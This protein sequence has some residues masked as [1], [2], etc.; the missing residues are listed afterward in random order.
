MSKRPSRR[1]EHEHE[2]QQSTDNRHRDRSQPERGRTR[3]V[4]AQRRSE[5]ALQ[6][7]IHIRDPNP[8]DDSDHEQQ[9]QQQVDE[10][11]N[12]NTQTN[13]QTNSTSVTSSSL[14]NL[15]RP[16]DLYR[17]PSARSSLSE[18]VSPVQSKKKKKKKEKRTNSHERRRQ[19][20]REEREQ[21]AA[22][23]FEHFNK[24]NVNSESSSS[25]SSSASSR[26]SSIE[27]KHDKPTSK[28][29]STTNKQS[30]TSTSKPTSSTARDSQATAPT[31]NSSTRI[32]SSGTKPTQR[33]VKHRP[34]SPPS[35]ESDNESDSAISGATSESDSAG[36]RNENESIIATNHSIFS[37]NSGAF[38]ASNS[39]Y[40]KQEK[41]LL[42]KKKKLEYSKVDFKLTFNNCSITLKNKHEFKEYKSKL[43]IY[44]QTVGARDLVTKPTEM[45]WKDLSLPFVAAATPIIVYREFRNV[46]TRLCGLLLSTVA[47]H[48]TNISSIEQEIKTKY[49][50]T[51]PNFIDEINTVTNQHVTDYTGSFF[52]GNPFLLFSYLEDRFTS[53]KQSLAYM[54]NKIT[55]L[56]IDNIANYHSTQQW[57]DNFQSNLMEVEK[58]MALQPPEPGRYLNNITVLSI[59]MSQLN[60]SKH[61]HIKRRLHELEPERM[62]LDSLISM[63]V[64]EENDRYAVRNNKVST[65]TSNTPNKNKGGNQQAQA[66]L[67]T[68]ETSNDQTLALITAGTQFNTGTK[69]SG[70]KK[71]SK[72]NRNKRN[73]DN[74]PASNK[75][76][77]VSATGDQNSSNSNNYYAS[78]AIEQ[79]DSDYSSGNSSGD[80][81]SDDS[82]EDCYDT[83]DNSNGI[84]YAAATYDEQ[85]N[86]MKNRTV[87][88]ISTNHNV[89]DLSKVWILDSGAT[90]HLTCIKSVFEEDTLHKL[91]PSVT[92]TGFAGNSTVAR[93]VGTVQLN[94]NLNITNM[95]Y[96]PGTKT[97]LISQS[98]LIQS[99]LRMRSHYH[100]Q[101]N[102]VH[103]I[104]FFEPAG[105]FKARDLITFCLCGRGLWI[106]KSNHVIEDHMEQQVHIRPRVTKKKETHVLVRDMIAA[107]K[108]TTSNSTSTSTSDTSTC[109]TSSTTVAPYSHSTA[110]PRPSTRKQ[111]PKKADVVAMN[112]SMA[113]STALPATQAI[114]KFAYVTEVTD[115]DT[116]SEEEFTGTQ[117]MVL[118]AH[119]TTP[120]TITD[121]NVITGTEQHNT[122]MNTSTVISTATKTNTLSAAE[123]HVRYGHVS[124]SRAAL[125]ALNCSDPVYDAATCETCAAV[126]IRKKRTGAGTYVDLYAGPM[127]RLDADIQGPITDVDELGRIVRIRSIG[128]AYYLLNVICHHSRF[129]FSIPL[130]KKS[131]AAQHIIN[132]INNI[133]TQY[134]ISV[135]CVHSDNG[136]EF[137][138]GTLQSYYTANGIVQSLS[139]AYS[140]STNGTVERC[141][142]TIM[143]M[144]KSMLSSSSAPS[145]LWGEA[146]IQAAR[147]HNSVPLKSLDF[148]S[149]LEVVTGRPAHVP[150]TVFGSDC[151]YKIEQHLIGKL[152]TAGTRG[153]VIGK[154]PNGIGYRIYTGGTVLVS[155]N[156]KLYNGS[157]KFMNA[158]TSGDTITD[159]HDE[160]VYVDG[161]EINN[162]SNKYEFSN[163]INLVNTDDEP[164]I[165]NDVDSTATYP[166]HADP[167]RTTSQSLS[168]ATHPQSTIQS[169]S[170]TTNNVSNNTVTENEIVQEPNIDYTADDGTDD[171]YSAAD[172]Q[173]D[174]EYYSDD[175]NSNE[176][177][178]SDDDECTGNDEI[179]TGTENYTATQNFTG[180]SNNTLSPI[181][182]EENNY[183]KYDVNNSYGVLGSISDNEYEDENNSSSEYD[184]DQIDYVPPTT[185]TTS[186]GRVSSAPTPF[187]PFVFTA[188]VNHE[189]TGT[190][191]T[192]TRTKSKFS[193]AASTT[194]S[195]GT[196]GVQVN[197]SQRS[198][199]AT[200]LFKHNDHSI[201][202][203]RAPVIGGT[204][205]D[206]EDFGLQSTATEPDEPQTFKSAMRSRDAS[207]WS[208]SM[209]DE[210][211]S[212]IK[213]QVLIKWNR[214]SNTRILGTRWVYKIKK[215]EHNQPI[216]WKSRLVAKG[217][218]QVEDLDFGETFSPVAHFDTLRLLLAIS[219]I[220]DTEIKQVD[221]KTAFL[222]A[223]LDEEIFISVPQGI[224]DEC[225]S[226]DIDPKQHCFKLNRALYG[227]KQSPRMW[228]KLLISELLLLGYQQCSSDPCLLFKHVPGSSI[229]ILIGVYVDDMIISV[230]RDVEHVWQSDKEA[231]MKKYEIDDLNDINFCLKMKIERDRI[232][233]TLTISQ[234]AYVHHILDEFNIDINKIRTKNNPSACTNLTD[235]DISGDDLL[236]ADGIQRYQQMVGSLMYLANTTRVD[237]CFSVHL[238]AR[239]THA[240]MSKH[241]KAA[242]HIIRYIAGTPEVCLV[243]T[244]AN[245]AT[246]KF[247]IS[248][249]Q[250]NCTG[251]KNNCTGTELFTADNN[252]NLSI[253]GYTDSDWAGSQ[254]SRVSTQGNIIMLN[255]NVISWDC[256]KQKSVSQSSTEAE[257]IAINLAARQ[258]VWLQCLINEVYGI[259]LTSTVYTDNQAAQAWCVSERVKHQRAK[260]ID[261]SY[262]YV[263]E[264]VNSG[265]LEIKYVPTDRNLADILTKGVNQETFINLRKQIM[266]TGE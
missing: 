242:H 136:G 98:A 59:A 170:T 78:I 102:T 142:Q 119:T 82:D 249:T 132:I 165:L 152:T 57:I 7:N 175:S 125:D 236:D 164:V 106:Y 261:I 163:E 186:S 103:C 23:L 13:V 62:N 243:Y 138:N 11:T 114:A 171:Y 32:R 162:I 101:N 85:V 16:S 126:R 84:A 203:T 75:P 42:N 89:I 169:N 34:P 222:N 10:Q 36:N 178:Y 218:E 64:N 21:A 191:S 204:D 8:S 79:K 223:S 189:D 247:P 3:S 184:V 193:A 197:S 257:F 9:H 259:H 208:A 109:I 188:V 263:R 205:S 37:T 88:L 54:S 221:F 76:F 47:S 49:L 194:I 207:K 43:F 51:N 112:R 131:E 265:A 30:S 66:H 27:R 41:R 129:I 14:A 248:G 97:N 100:E 55:N 192:A 251:T 238:L 255:N 87:K 216:R 225:I 121:T 160:F 35:S 159:Y 266:F 118:A 63:L 156:V 45:N 140:P 168:I 110:I 137:V 2:Q 44:L 198:N 108:N 95:I 250:T 4:S 93:E 74:L 258:V 206:D 143:L 146:A 90:R 141:N 182:E 70:G 60:E 172:E 211:R 161:T 133:R 237:I 29:K 83:D 224:E 157:F 195:G 33:R 185:T 116:D 227:L 252:F 144:V 53:S 179:Y 260:H 229:P 174:E 130:T 17:P 115:T 200:S 240:P 99:G 86:S 187:D 173:S 128:G 154:S 232:N 230:H 68:N 67:A 80:D 123:F 151:L 39:S 91:N 135:R 231:I 262:K 214:A 107:D 149:P 12:T 220:H 201:E 31:T 155:T 77:T 48:F 65:A 199:T 96:T 120:T 180:T 234:S 183:D 38:K 148:R 158:V 5:F 256:K 139:P 219:T 245:L 212:I 253:N 26:S 153:I 264:I 147:I 166:F 15:P 196:S 111:I 92:I 190:I 22:R 150:V 18:H 167:I 215:N 176:H 202:S 46:C 69:S 127:L 213:N 239:Y 71:K 61:V 228:Y 233:G 72:S 113:R 20:R 181:K 210:F 94:P 246:G 124:L 24:L 81:C 105:K 104:T 28:S 254:D 1:D 241:M 6:T 52:D 177:K 56:T 73:Q 122:S 134:G 40:T 145:F 117:L 235:P 58:I 244:R 217:Y 50:R 209:K 25:C 19:L 226:N